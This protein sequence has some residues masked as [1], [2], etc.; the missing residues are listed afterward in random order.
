MNESL[1]E[2]QSF[3]SWKMHLRLKEKVKVQD[4]E[5]FWLL[6]MA[7]L[8]ERYM[9]KNRPERLQPDG[10]GQACVSSTSNGRAEGSIQEVKA[11]VQRV[12]K[13]A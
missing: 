6:K 4:M 12:L 7:V 5:K 8:M 11:R 13:F 9:A 1:K 3:C 10:G 2:E